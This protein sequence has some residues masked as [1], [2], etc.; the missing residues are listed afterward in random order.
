MDKLAAS[1]TVL[2]IATAPAL[3]GLPDPDAV[4]LNCQH[5]LAPQGCGSC[6]GIWKPVS[7]CAA[8]I[9][10]PRAPSHVFNQ[11][12]SDTE[13]AA[14]YQPMSYDRLIATLQC[15]AARGAR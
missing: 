14:N 3:A 11:C 1:L 6:S 5:Q 8:S 12:A 2:L 4:I 13:V 9:L 15:V 10:Y 7:R